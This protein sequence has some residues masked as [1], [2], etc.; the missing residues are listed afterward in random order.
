M[1]KNKSTEILERWQRLD[2]QLSR[3]RLEIPAF[4]K[5]R[6]VSSKTVYRD[7]EAFKELGQDIFIADQEHVEGC[8]VINR[9]GYRRD[10][11]RLFTWEPPTAKPRRTCTTGPNRRS[12]FW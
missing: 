9:W 8:L 10:C 4:A 6:K 2:Y 1:P 11:Q 7:L 5:Q 3:R 12:R